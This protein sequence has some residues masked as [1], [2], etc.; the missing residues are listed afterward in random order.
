M[1]RDRREFIAAAAASTVAC[2]RRQSPWR[3][4]TSGEARTIEAVCEQIVPADQDP[5]AARA[6]VV[7]FLDRQLSGFHK[8]L[9]D[10]YR[11]GIAEID[12]VALQRFGARF[13]DLDAPRQI[14]ILKDLEKRRAP[15]SS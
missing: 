5:G 13:A 14:E 6:G 9:Q 3:F 7:A 4:F 2:G 12:R 11:A 10:T 8:S 1:R 15:F